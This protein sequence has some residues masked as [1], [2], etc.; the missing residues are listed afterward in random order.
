MN[1]NAPV[2][3]TVSNRITGCA[4]MVAN[5]LGSGLLEKL[6]ENALSFISASRWVSMLSIFWSRMPS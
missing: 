6:Y 2:L 1:T 3:D 5:G 4:L